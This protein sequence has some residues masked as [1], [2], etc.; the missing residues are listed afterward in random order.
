MKVKPGQLRQWTDGP[1]L[2]DDYLKQTFLLVEPK[3]DDV[4]WW[5][6]MGGKIVWEVT[7]II[8]LDS[9]ILCEEDGE[10]NETR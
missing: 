9:D 6:L 7:D 5:I 3:A 10:H 8:E 1:H 4:G 2:P